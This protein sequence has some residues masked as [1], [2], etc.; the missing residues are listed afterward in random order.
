TPMPARRPRD[1]RRNL[2]VAAIALGLLLMVRST[3]LWLGDAFMFPLVV[4]I[5]GFAVLAVVRP[6][7]VR[8]TADS[9]GVVGKA[10]G[11]FGALRIVA[12]AA[13]VALRVP[14]VG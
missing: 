10:D 9:S 13:P 5:A 3:G 4:I 1:Q 8:I 11:R 14:V 7:D 2:A 12:G 6:G